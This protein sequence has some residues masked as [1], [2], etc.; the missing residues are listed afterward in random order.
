VRAYP[1]RRARRLGAEGAM[2]ERD[3]GS[4]RWEPGG[5]GHAEGQPL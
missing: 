4:E 2:H 1:L 3:P 5:P